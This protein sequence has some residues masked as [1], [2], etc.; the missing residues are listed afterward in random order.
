MIRKFVN[1]ERELDFLDRKY[2]DAGLQVIVI[3]GRRRVGK[4][5]L[6][7]EFIKGKNSIYFLADKRGTEKN[8]ERFVNLV[9]ER[10]N[11]PPLKIGS[12]EDAFKIIVEKVKGERFIVVIDEFSYLIE[13]DTALS[14]VFQLIIDE[15][16]RNS[17]LFLILCGSSIGM[18]E[19]GVLSY[20]SPLYGRRTG[21]I[22][23]TPMRFKDLKKFFPR[24]SIKELIETYSVLGGI[25]A[26]LSLFDPAKR[27]DDNIQKTFCVKE[28]LFY[29]EPEIILKEELREPKVYFNLLEAIA[30]GKTKL[31]DIANKAGIN[32]KDASSY[33]NSLIELDLVE[34]T[35][36][37]TE[38]KPRTKKTI[39]FIKDN[40]FTF[41]FKFI[42]ENKEK[43][44]RG[45]AEVLLKKIK[46]EFSRYVSK[47]FEKVSIEFLWAEKIFP[48]TKIG[49]WWGTYRDKETGERKSV[50][51]D[52]VALNEETKEILFGE[53]KWQ[54]KVDGEKILQTLKEKS[55]FVDWNKNKR[56]EQ[57]A[58]FAKSF[59]K[60]AK[61]CYCFDLKDIYK[62]L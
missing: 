35:Y 17:N 10:L 16:L 49:K 52:I 34:R 20:K 47:T 54:D 33:I 41:W 7:K 31:T 1:R 51:I 42:L 13:K 32:A 18:M 26:Y 45:E 57:Y 61:K 5:E 4:T 53:C 44:E 62:S 38:K 11:L 43:I 2:K 48:F 12:F 15:I 58:I 60:R 14:S 56:K 8:I 22:K 3:Y 25:P 36:L 59:R 24:Y 50:E 19:K 6:I 23:L 46:G 30:I 37:I 29:E 27:L 39:Y 9:Q 40:F 55:E 28:H 21:Q